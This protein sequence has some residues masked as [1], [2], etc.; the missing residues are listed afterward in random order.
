MKFTNKTF[1]AQEK[2]DPYQDEITFE[3]CHF[4]GTDLRNIQFDQCEFVECRFE[5]TRILHT[6]F[7]E[8]VFEDCFLQGTD[9]TLLKSLLLSFTI[10]GGNLR[11]T[12][13]QNVNLTSCSFDSCD[14]KGANFSEANLTGIALTHSNLKD[15]EWEGAKLNKADLRGSTNLILHPSNVQ[16]NKAVLSL[17]QLPGLLTQTGIVIK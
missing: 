16:L 8:C 1:S 13:F 2:L 15:C 14:L 5:N 17:D 6:S 11:Y 12:N 4:N 10:Q 7:Q 3:R 9:F